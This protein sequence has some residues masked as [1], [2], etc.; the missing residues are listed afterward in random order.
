MHVDRLCPLTSLATGGLYQDLATDRT[1]AG[2][3]DTGGTAFPARVALTH[4]RL[5]QLAPRLC[6]LG[7][8]LVR[9]GLTCYGSNALAP[10][11]R[12]SPRPLHPVRYSLPIL[13]VLPAPFHCLGRSP[14]SSHLYH[15]TATQA[16]LPLE[17]GR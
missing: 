13:R 12:I 5:A 17:G 2:T 3:I 15:Y 1:P 14:W 9:V 4:F 6:R 8:W 10:H 7:M 16:V 11:F